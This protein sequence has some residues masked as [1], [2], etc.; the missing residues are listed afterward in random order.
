MY[1]CMGEEDEEGEDEG[2]GAPVERDCSIIIEDGD[3]GFE[4]SC[5]GYADK[6][7]G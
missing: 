3:A 1:T 7:A 6:G 4:Y 5:S 2:D